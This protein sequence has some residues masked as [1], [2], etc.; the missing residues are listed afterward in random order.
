MT[1]VFQHWTYAF[2]Q[3]KLCLLIWNHHSWKIH[4]LIILL[5]E[6]PC[7]FAI[8]DWEFCKTFTTVWKV[9]FAKIF[10]EYASIWRMMMSRQFLSIT[11][12][13]VSF[14]LFL[15]EAIK[16]ERG[17]NSDISVSEKA[18]VNVNDSV[19][20][21]DFLCAPPT[22]K[23]KIMLIDMIDNGN[24]ENVWPSNREVLRFYSANERKKNKQVVA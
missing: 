21:K 14:R 5:L 24:S 22:P 2:V 12:W 1:K 19:V 6:P 13:Y 9:P 20:R 8:I 16:K 17:N 4:S 15:A 10:G 3:S 7:S 11:H 23:K 18:D